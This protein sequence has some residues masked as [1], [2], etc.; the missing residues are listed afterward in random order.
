M[1]ENTSEYEIHINKRTDR[2]YLSKVIEQKILTRDNVNGVSEISRPFRILSKV[3]DNIESHEFIK[4]GKELKLRI[5]EGQRHEIIA[6]FYEDTRGIF[7]LQIQKF[8]T[9]T[10]NPHKTYFTFINEEIGTLYNFIRNIAILPIAGDQGQ[11]I[12]DKY[13]EDIILTKEQT[14]KIINENPKLVAEI[15]KNNISKAD[16]IAIGYRKEQLE[17]FKK[18]LGDKSYFDNYK[19]TNDIAKDETVWQTFFEKNTWIFGY[20]LNYIFNSP[21]QGKKLEQVVSGYN[22]FSAGKRIDALMQTKG[23]VSSLCFGEIKT[24]T[25]P[26]LNKEYRSECYS[27]SEEV[28]GGIAQ[29]QKTIQKSLKELNSKLDIKDK[30][31]N[32]TGESVF[33]FQPKSFLVVGSLGQFRNGHGINED[34]FGSFELYRRNITSP[35]II[36]FDE[37]YERARFIVDTSDVED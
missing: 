26:L 18:L 3:I 25:T 14:L 34:K 11:R 23:L 5:T 33:I 36:T 8:S 27:V 15:L 31:R 13:L 17:I 30:E 35:E 21:L 7:T 37:L 24:H 1:L 10:G 9:D 20:G 29:V 22:V 32:P 16:L 2:I 28:S 19:L 6:K 12:D 4:E